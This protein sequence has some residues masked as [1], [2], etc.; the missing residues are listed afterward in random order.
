MKLRTLELKDASGMVEWMTDPQIN[1]FFRFEI[2]DITIESAE[3]F[4]RKARE[5]GEQ[6]K[7]YHYAIADEQDRYLGTISLKNI[8]GIVKSA[9]YAISLR[10]AAQGR[11]IASWATESILRMAFEEMGLQRIYLNVLSEN[12]NAIRLY[13]KMGFLYEGEF[14]NHLDVHG[15]IKSLKWYAMLR[16]EYYNRGDKRHEDNA[17]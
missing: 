5:E 12:Y 14:R 4:I 6:G 15:E 16:E 1:K 2:K 3:Q 10:K 11:G 17:E 7:T 9:E 13:E 8:D